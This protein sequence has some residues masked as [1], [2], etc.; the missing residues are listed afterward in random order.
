MKRSILLLVLLLNVTTSIW[1]CTECL[2]HDGDFE[3]YTYKGNVKTVHKV[4]LPL[5]KDN[6]GNKKIGKDTTNSWYLTFDRQKECMSMESKTCDPGLYAFKKY[7][8]FNGERKLVEF[9]MVRRWKNHPV[10]DDKYIYSENGILREEQSLDSKVL[11][12]PEGKEHCRIFYKYPKKASKESQKEISGY[13]YTYYDQNGND[14][15]IVFLDKDQKTL[16]RTKKAYNQ[17]DKLTEEYYDDTLVSYHKYDSIGRLVADSSAYDLYGEKEDEDRKIPGLSEFDFEDN[18][19][20]PS[21]IRTYEY[22]DRSLK[23]NYFFV[24]KGF[25]EHTEEVEK[26]NEKNK[27]I[28]WK[29]THYDAHGKETFSYLQRYGNDNT[30]EPIEIVE[31]R[32]GKLVRIHKRKEICNKNEKVITTIDGRN[33][34]KPDTVQTVTK[35]DAKGNILSIVE[36]KNSQKETQTLYTYNKRGQLLSIVSED[37]Y[38][39]NDSFLDIDKIEYRYDKRHNLVSEIASLKG[40]VQ[41]RL[42]YHYDAKNCLIS[43]EKEKKDWIKEGKFHITKTKYDKMGNAIEIDYGLSIYYITYTYYEE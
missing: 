24:E 25:I 41:R 36:Y 13:Q 8:R 19:S 10:I 20:T 22:G 21:L 32:D 17:W 9:K 39:A 12:N 40:K 43:E 11:Y 38:I 1:A 34:E 27:I 26:R 23:T 18:I 6:L 28:E 3:E 2:I 31:Y 15:A 5:Y 35:F 37:G 29:Y 7:E 30:S 42:T 16:H 33:G 14:T 4:S